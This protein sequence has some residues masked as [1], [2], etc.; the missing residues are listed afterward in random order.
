[1]D[2]RV[3][4]DAGE[5][6]HLQRSLFLWLLAILLAL[7][8]D[9]MV[10]GLFQ[11]LAIVIKRSEFAHEIKEAGHFV[12]VLILA[13]FVWILHPGRWRGAAL[14]CVSAI[15]AGLFYSMLKWP[16]GRVRPIVAIDPFH[17]EPFHYGMAGLFRG[18]NASF[19]SGHVCVA[20]ATAAG[21]S[22]L[23]PRGRW[24][25]YTVAGLLAF[26]RVGELA[27][28]LSDVIAAAGLGVLAF[29]LARVGLG[30]LMALDEAGAD[31]GGIM[32]PAT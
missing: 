1:M 9:G 28:Y 21:M 23:L 12:F 26:E 4:L 19:P 6:R 30:S 14:L 27:H 10:A 8:L 18:G 29:H 13:A 3:D 32:R 5:Q 15:L 7:P 31:S 17:F 22:W 2:G 20:F 25:F 24:A 16:V 11:P